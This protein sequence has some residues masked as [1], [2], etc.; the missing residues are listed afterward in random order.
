M[1]RCAFG[2]V[3]ISRAGVARADLVAVLAAG[4]MGASVLCVLGAGVTRH[5]MFTPSQANL[6]IIGQAGAAY[7][8]DFQGH[9]PM[10]PIWQHRGVGP[11]FPNQSANGW[12]AWAYGGK[13]TSAYWFSAFGG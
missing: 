7:Q 8:G 13:N 4:L 12:A 5:R 6:L 3:G 1:P 9:L 2:R 10:A 11:A